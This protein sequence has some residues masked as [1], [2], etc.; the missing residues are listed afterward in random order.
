MELGALICTPVAPKC[1]VCSLAPGCRARKEGKPD[2]Y[3]FRKAKAKVPHR[4]VGAGIII[5]NHGEILIARRKDD[6]MLGGLWEFPGGGVEVGEPIA[7][8]IRRE[9]HE[10]LGITARVGPHLITVRHAFS[11]FTMDLHAHWV[12]ISRGK[13]RAIG[14]SE[15]TWVK[16]SGLDAYAL[17][18]ADQKIRDAVRKVKQWP[19]F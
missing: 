11:H 7:D 10:E 13:P 3:P 16:L 4:H 1:E 18:R 2:R 15:F 6:A 14:C 8:C 12:R 5:N 9:L 19:V 17:P